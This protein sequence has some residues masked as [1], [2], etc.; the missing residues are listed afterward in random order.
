MV[1]A[2]GTGLLAADPMVPR[3]VSIR[4]KQRETHDT[5]T[6][7]LDVPDPERGLPFVPGQFTM[8]Y[9]FG[10]GEVPISISGDPA[11]PM[12]LVHTIRAVGSVTRP[13][14]AL[15]QGS[16]LGVRGPFGSGWPIEEARGRDILVI[17]GG[18][19]L[20]PLRPLVY[21]LLNRRG[22]YGHI[23]IVCGARSPA[24]I[25]FRHE[26][27]RWGGRFD[28]DV[29]VIVD[30]ATDTWHGDVG[31]VT[32]LLD[33]SRCEPANTRAMICGPEIMMRF[34]IRALNDLGISDEQIH[35]SMERNMQCAIGMCGHCQYGPAF[36]C[37]DGPV[38]RF[39]RIRPLFGAREI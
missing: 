34:S 7:T 8:L 23:S 25:L 31:V 36:V 32:R 30:H 27:E 35:I 17:A 18:L 2:A 13:L 33:K 16:M 26:L 1:G 28:V 39:D 21:H 12:Q 9:L 20:A 22:D 14:Q 37:K 3:P 24:D 15:Q 10:A 29:A 11:S 5:F 4:R 6:L 38:F 19:G